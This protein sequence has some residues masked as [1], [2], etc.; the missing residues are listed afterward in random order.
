MASVS[1][2][3][4]HAGGGVIT[5]VAVRVTRRPTAVIVT[6]SSGRIDVLAVPPKKLALVC[7]VVS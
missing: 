3:G 7:P 1:L 4:A 5:S 2:W 6:V